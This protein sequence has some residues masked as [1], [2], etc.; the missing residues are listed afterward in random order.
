MTKKS[1]SVTWHAHS[2]TTLM[3]RGLRRQQSIEKSHFRQEN[4]DQVHV[5]PVVVGALGG[6]IKVMRFDLKKILKMM[7][8]WSKL[9]L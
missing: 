4:D 2:K 3:Q 9:L 8:C 6:G 1:R 7:N 5:V